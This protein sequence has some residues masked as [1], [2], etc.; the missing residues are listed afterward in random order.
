MGAGSLHVLVGGSGEEI[1]NVALIC[2]WSRNVRKDCES[3]LIVAIILITYHSQ[4]QRNQSCTNRTL[5]NF[6]E[7]QKGVNIHLVI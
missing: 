3:A 1:V 2:H 6:Y 4:Q 5:T 7:N